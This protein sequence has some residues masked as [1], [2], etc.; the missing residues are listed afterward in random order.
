MLSMAKVGLGHIFLY[1]IA[2]PCGYCSKNVDD[3]FFWLTV[4]SGWSWWTSWWTWR[5]WGWS[6]SLKL[7]TVGDFAA[8]RKTSSGERMMDL[9]IFFRKILFILLVFLMDM[10]VCCCLSHNWSC[11]SWFWGSKTWAKSAA[12]N[13][14]TLSHGAQNN[15]WHFI[16]F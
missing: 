8:R 10:L 1:A 9:V 15:W 16:V 2:T 13:R 5:W 12:W 7:Y 3:P 4:G 6:S 11:F 14:L